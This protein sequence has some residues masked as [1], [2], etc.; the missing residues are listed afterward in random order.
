MYIN[1]SE[2]AQEA[3]KK[4]LEDKDK[5]NTFLRVFMKGFG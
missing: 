1:I 5:N 4:Q 3:I 2:K